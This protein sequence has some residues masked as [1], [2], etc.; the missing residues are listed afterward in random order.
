MNI[1][2]DKDHRVR[3]TNVHGQSSSYY[4]IFF[5]VAE[6]T[7]ESGKPLVMPSQPDSICH[8][9][10]VDDCGDAYVAIASHPRRAEVEGEVFNISA[11]RYE[12]V[13]N[14]GQA[15]VSEYGIAD[16]L[17]YVDPTNHADGHDWP[18]YLIDFPQWTG[19][20][21]LRR[22]T[23]WS[24]HR[25]LFTESIHLYRVAYEAAKARRSG[26]IEKVKAHWIELIAESE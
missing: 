11:R 13:A 25:P 17:Q 9:L 10:H 3:P 15:L 26:N 21:K 12:T 8:S 19:S 16:G 6:K 5:E 20:D 22:L 4:G 2:A 23:G 14:L 18:P 7:A 1:L 24:D